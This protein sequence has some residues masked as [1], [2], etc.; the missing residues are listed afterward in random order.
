MLGYLWGGEEECFE[1]FV[2]VNYAAEFFT[3]VRCGFVENGASVGRHGLWSL[4]FNVV[5]SRLR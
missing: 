2:V 5:R 4:I 3:E 1:D